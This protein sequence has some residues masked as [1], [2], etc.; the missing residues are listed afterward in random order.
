MS[1][2]RV[3][4]NPDDAV[5]LARIINMPPRGIGAKS[6][7]DLVAW[8][9]EQQL[10]LFTA[11]QRIAAA[12]ANKTGDS[13]EPTGPLPL[14]NRAT[15]A[16]ANF[17]DITAAID[18]NA[19]DFT[20]RRCRFTAA[21]ADM[22]ALIW[23]QDAAAAASDRITV[24]DCYVLT[25]DAANTHFINLAGTGDG[26]VIRNNILMGDWGTMCI[27]GAGI[28]TNCAIIGNYIY[29]KATE[30]DVCISMGATAT[31]ICAGNMCC[32]GHASQGIIPGDLGALE[33]YYEQHT[34]DLSGVIEPATA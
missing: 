27:G 31:G 9:Q 14:S 28:V 21:A 8:A 6:M 1:Y 20:L 19:T 15:T 29:N 5:S 4:H 17:A 25:P 16:V 10:P 11:M 13:E 33:N 23:V 32:G 34:S 22:N 26:H 18:V 30:A 12:K 3:I 24:E 2:L 7:Q